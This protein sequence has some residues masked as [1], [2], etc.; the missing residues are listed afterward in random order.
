MRMS[1]VI[2]I[3]I[4]GTF[5]DGVA[6]DLASGALGTA[7]SPTT[8]PDPFAGVMSVID[9]LAA[10]HDRERGE[11]LRET[12]KFV[13]ATTL[14]SNVL[15]ERRGASVGL[16]ATQGFGDAILMMSGKGRVAGLSLMERRHFRATNKPEPIVPRRHVVEVAERVD[17]DG[18]VVVSLTDEAIQETVHQVEQLGLMH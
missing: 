3:D 15:L 4:G 17:V 9:E 18:D 10:C 7:K 16:V 5:T 12:D 13:H 11:L 14:T 6:I 2:G 8:D 1:F